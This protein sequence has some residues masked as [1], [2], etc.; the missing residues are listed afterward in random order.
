MQ[1]KKKEVSHIFKKGQ[2]Y[3]YPAVRKSRI[4]EK[5]ITYG[6]GERNT[7]RTF[8]NGREKQNNL[9][10]RQEREGEPRMK[11]SLLPRKRTYF[12][13]RGGEGGRKNRKGEPL[14]RNH[15]SSRYKISN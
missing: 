14:G 15:R 4:W 9:K 2:S 13:K 8:S 1:R 10:G 5:P 7:S 11:R 12:G 3:S 6:K